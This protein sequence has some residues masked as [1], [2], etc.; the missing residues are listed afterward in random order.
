[1]K[2]STTKK[3]P[4]KNTK[5]KKK[6]FKLFALSNILVAIT[7][8]AFTI[9]GYL[10]MAN[11]NKINDN[12]KNEKIKEEKLKQLIIE[13]QISKNEKVKYFEE[14]TKALEIEY[15]SNIDN[16]VYIDEKKVESKDKF[17]YKDETQTYIKQISDNIVSKEKLVQEEIIKEIEPKL[18]KKEIPKKEKVDLPIIKKDTGLPKLAVIIDD[19]TTSYQIK[20]IQ[21][22]G[23]IVNMAFLPPTK[24]HRNSA[25]VTNN[26]NDYMIHLPLEA[27][28][29]R[30]EEVDT[31]YI[32]HSIEKIDNKIKT[33][34]SLYPKA[35]FINNH[36]GS[37][38]TSNKQAMDK[39]LKV[40]K[41]YNYTFI[42]SKTTAKSV[43]LESA[44]KYD[45][46]VLTRNIFLDNK[47]DKKYIQKQLKR[48]VAIAK[49]NG[50]AIAIGHPYSITFSTLKESKHLLKGVELVFVKSL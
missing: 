43:V 5:S 20:R 27:S 37:K 21:D 48:A 36:T 25:K 40:L 14:K 47:K 18:V 50:S 46:R 33:L 8:I 24:H 10:Y 44:K 35:T 6:P 42:D 2:K 30:Y 45:I 28:S 34:K 49:K 7:A 41:K 38:Y 11:E 29:H 9:I 26:L 4:L 12:I 32:G 15:V 13:D 19:V 22:I 39:L 17:K 3:P 23:Y 16:Q 31:L 1:M